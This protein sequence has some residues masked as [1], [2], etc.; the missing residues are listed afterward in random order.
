MSYQQQLKTYIDRN[1]LTITYEDKQIAEQLFIARV[2]INKDTLHYSVYPWTT[3]QPS[4]KIAKQEAAKIALDLIENDK[5][6]YSDTKPI[7]DKEDEL[8]SDTES[9]KDILLDI[10]ELLRN[11]VE[12]I[13]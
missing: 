11:L 8:Y 4:K 7:L 10:R 2:L 13:K 5:D 3:N 12:K 1:N 6:I 9:I